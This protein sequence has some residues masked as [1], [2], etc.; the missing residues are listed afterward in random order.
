M[1]LTFALISFLLALTLSNTHADSL[2]TLSRQTGCLSNR[3]KCGP[4]QLCLQIPGGPDVC[5]TGRTLGQNC[6]PPEE[7]WASPC[8]PPLTCI[9]HRCK[10]APGNKQ[11]RG[12]IAS[13]GHSCSGPNVVCDRGLSCRDGRCKTLNA[14]EGTLCNPRSYNI[15]KTQLKCMGPERLQRCVKLV[16]KGKPC[17]FPYWTC[18]QGLQCIAHECRTSK[19]ARG[20]ACFRS[21]DCAGRT[22]CVIVGN[23]AVGKCTTSLSEGHVC[24]ESDGFKSFVGICGVGLRCMLSSSSPTGGFC[25][26][27]S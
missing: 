11:C 1:H 15:C 10:C 27:R 23:N 13:K 7:D 2:N 21:D 24:S 22:E 6:S 26:R 16:P 8:L 17:A 20:A 9:N 14:E 18:E 4:K 25:V 19:L 12:R 3:V 5:Y